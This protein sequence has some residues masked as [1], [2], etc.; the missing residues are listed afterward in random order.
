VLDI[1]AL[2]E[3]QGQSPDQIVESLPQLSL[4]QVHAALAYYFANRDEI[5]RQLRGE[6]DLALR[7]RTLTGPGPLE[8]KLQGKDSRRDSIPS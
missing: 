6:E 2:S 1:Y 8:V 7:F 5:V 4:A 3:L